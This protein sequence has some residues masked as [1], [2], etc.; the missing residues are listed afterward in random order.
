MVENQ[1]PTLPC[2]S[3]RIQLPVTR[4]P[5]VKAQ[6]AKFSVFWLSTVEVYSSACGNLNPSSLVSALTNTA[7]R[8]SSVQFRYAERTRPWSADKSRKLHQGVVSP[9]A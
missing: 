4:D 8:S 2:C 1:L 9:A 6:S 5:F 3:S 7:C